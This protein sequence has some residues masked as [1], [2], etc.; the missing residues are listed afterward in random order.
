[1]ASSSTLI[2]IWAVKIDWALNSGTRFRAGL[3]PMTITILIIFL[4]FVL[5]S[6]LK[7]DQQDFNLYR[8]VA[9]GFEWAW[10]GCQILF[11]WTI[12]RDL[13]PKLSG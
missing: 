3:T 1:M 6:Y 5:V 13:R 2:F 9:A 10:I 4:S 11:L 8:Q 12:Y 7:R